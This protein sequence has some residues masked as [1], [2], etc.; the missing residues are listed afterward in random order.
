MTD[1]R[2]VV[3][4]L[5]ALA[6]VQAQLLA[7]TEAKNKA[8][9]SVLTDVQRDELAG[10]D[11]EYGP[12]LAMAFKAAEDLEYQIKRAVLELGCTI[13]TDKLM[14]VWSKG[15][16]SWDVKALE[17]Y[18][19]GHPEILVFRTSDPDPSVSIRK[20]AAK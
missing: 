12:Q 16:P 18:A 13:K 2:T 7:I 14:A 6:D 1:D 10:I 17:G 15:R 9:D 19:V 20:V 5:S 8:R 11:L 4:L 3:E